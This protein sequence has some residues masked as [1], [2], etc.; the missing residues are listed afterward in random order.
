M[1][2]YKSYSMAALVSDQ[3]FTV[4]DLM[5]F[6]CLFVFVGVFLVWKFF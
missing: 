1:S 6:F 4:K 3:K 5:L 2:I